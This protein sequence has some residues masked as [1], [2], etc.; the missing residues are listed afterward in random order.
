[1]TKLR[2]YQLAY[3]HLLELWDKEKSFLEE[4]PNNNIAK[5]RLERYDAELDELHSELPK[6]EKQFA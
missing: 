6:L 3:N 5:A 4:Y 2:I 1:M